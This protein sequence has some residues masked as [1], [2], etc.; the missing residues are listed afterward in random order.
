MMRSRIEKFTRENSIALITISI[1]QR[2]L[3]Q[4][5]ITL[6]VFKATEFEWEVQFKFELENLSKVTRGVAP[7]SILDKGRE[8]WYPKLEF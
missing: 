1:F 5:L 4:R 2:D 3:V 8:F 7:A 6:R